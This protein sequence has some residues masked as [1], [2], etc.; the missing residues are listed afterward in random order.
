VPSVA[1]IAHTVSLKVEGIGYEH[2]VL[3]YILPFINSNFIKLK[4]E[5]SMRNIK[6]VF[7]TT[8]FSIFYLPVY[9]LET[10][11]LVK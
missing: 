1:L 4:T 10:L 9:Y 3:L 5:K 6:G 8:V 11:R 2:L 7:Y